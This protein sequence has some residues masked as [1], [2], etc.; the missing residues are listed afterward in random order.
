[1][2]RNTANNTNFHY[3]TNSVK[4]NDKIFQHIKKALFLAAKNFF[5]ENLALSHT[6]SYGFLASWQNLEK[7]ED[8]IPRKPLDRRKNGQTLFYRTLPATVGGLT[9]RILSLSIYDFE[10]FR[11]KLLCKEKFYST[12]AVTKKIIHKEYDRVLNV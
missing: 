6:T 3:K 4:I 5:L 9:K 12:L 8:T 11:E 10:K 7:T 2:C 1:M